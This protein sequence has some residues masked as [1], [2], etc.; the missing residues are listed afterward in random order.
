MPPPSGN[1]KKELLLANSTPV[2]LHL[3]KERGQPFCEVTGGRYW[4]GQDLE[5]LTIAKK[6]KVELCPMMIT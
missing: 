3:L 1:D 6:L 2:I 4:N 5:S